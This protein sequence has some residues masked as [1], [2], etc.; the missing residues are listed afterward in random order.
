METGGLYVICYVQTSCFVCW[1][2]LTNIAQNH[3]I[4][5]LGDFNIKYNKNEYSTK[6]LKDI[7][8]E[9]SLKQLI[10]VP[11]RTTSTDTPHIAKS[12][13]IVCGISDH[14]LIQL[15]H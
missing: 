4:T 3:E 11:T 5:I 8:Q 9:K 15:S 13:V 2:I 6:A 14:E 1:N 12:G 10:K 7:F